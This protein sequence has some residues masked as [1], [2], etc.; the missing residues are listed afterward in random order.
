MAHM[1]QRSQ[2]SYRQVRAAQARS[3][4]TPCGQTTSLSTSHILAAETPTK[5]FEIRHASCK[6]GRLAGPGYPSTFA[7]VRLS[8][9]S[10]CMPMLLAKKDEYMQ[11]ILAN[12]ACSPTPYAGTRRAS[13][14]AT[15]LQSCIC[16]KRLRLVLICT[17]SSCSDNEFCNN[18]TASCRQQP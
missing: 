9:C 15:R 17:A 2:A 14:A 10:D 5:G 3:V 1:T 13:L 12:S 7:I 6:S 4:P 16:G 11:L 18:I 8:L